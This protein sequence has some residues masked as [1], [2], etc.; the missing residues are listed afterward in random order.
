M[1]K[2]LTK[3]AQKGDTF[4]SQRYFS[5]WLAKKYYITGSFKQRQGKTIYFDKNNRRIKPLGTK[6]T[7]LLS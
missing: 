2:W 4:N 6:I 7:K 1:S 5:S 3:L